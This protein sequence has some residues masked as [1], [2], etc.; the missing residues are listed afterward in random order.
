MGQELVGRLVPIEPS[1]HRE[2]LSAVGK[3]V[4]YALTG[5]EATVRFAEVRLTHQHL[6]CCIER[7]VP[8]QSKPGT[9]ICCFHRSRAAT[10]CDVPAGS[11][12]RQAEFGDG[13]AC[14]VGTQH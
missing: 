5:T 13:S 4:E 10:R 9:K 12:H 3:C 2:A 1:R 8:M 11:R 14:W 7:T 6:E